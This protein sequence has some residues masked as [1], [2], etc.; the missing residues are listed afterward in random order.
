MSAPPL[1]TVE[2]STENF[3]DKEL[4][5]FDAFAAGQSRVNVTI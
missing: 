3:L 4:S 1:P 5:P 2:F